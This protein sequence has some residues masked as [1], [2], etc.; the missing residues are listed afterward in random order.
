MID[1]A[2]RL[3]TSNAAADTSSVNLRRLVT[4]FCVDCHQTD[5]AEAGVE[6]HR[7]EEHRKEAE[8]NHLNIVIAG[9][10]SS[11][12]LGMNLLIDASLESSGI[13]SRM[14]GGG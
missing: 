10:I 1:S 5:G 8:K 4:R 3:T 7:R 14:S 11:D 12:N 13:F 9:H 2:P 6:K